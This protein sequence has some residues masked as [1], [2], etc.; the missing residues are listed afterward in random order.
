MLGIECRYCAYCFDEGL[1]AREMV[2][3]ADEAQQQAV[4]DDLAAVHERT[5]LEAV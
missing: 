4:K 3:A 1:Y 2:E 5:K